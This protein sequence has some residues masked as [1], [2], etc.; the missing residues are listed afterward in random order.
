MAPSWISVSS[1][2]SSFPDR[3]YWERLLL[4]VSPKGRSDHGPAPRRRPQRRATQRSVS[5][6]SNTHRQMRLCLNMVMVFFCVY[7][8]RLQNK[9]DSMVYLY[10]IWFLYKIKKHQPLSYKQIISLWPL[11]LACIMFQLYLALRVNNKGLCVQNIHKSGHGR[12]W[13][14]F[15]GLWLSS[16][17]WHWTWGA[18]VNLDEGK[19]CHRVVLCCNERSRTR[20][21]SLKGQINN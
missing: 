14:F 20:W 6:A 11:D 3:T 7:L 12:I 4:T 16:V 21:A 19:L 18:V 9:Q 8:K 15:F 1:C 13:F 17:R 10:K 2:V 5:E